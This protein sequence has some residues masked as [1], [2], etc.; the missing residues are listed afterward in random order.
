MTAD[1]QSP[2]LNSFAIL[3]RSYQSAVQLNI[4][5]L[6]TASVHIGYTKIYPSDENGTIC[7]LVVR[8]GRSGNYVEAAT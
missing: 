3:T 1:I 8:K 4:L 7:D 6:F 2:A 5:A